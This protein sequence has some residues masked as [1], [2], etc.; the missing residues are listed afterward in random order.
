MCEWV[1]RAVSI[2]CYDQSVYQGL[3][4]DVDS[5]TST[6]TLRNII[7]NGQPCEQNSLSI[8]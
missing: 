3:V 2:E 5:T 8:L 6:V 4:A 1:D 7:R